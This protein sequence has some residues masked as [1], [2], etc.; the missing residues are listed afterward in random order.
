MTT[1]SGA[2]SIQI[3]LQRW[4][5]L[6]RFGRSLSLDWP[7]IVE[8]PKLD[9]E[10]EVVGAY[11]F[12][13][14]LVAFEVHDVNNPVLYRPP[15]RRPSQMPSCIGAAKCPLE[16]H[17]VT[18]H[19]QLFDIEAQIGERKVVSAD[20]LDSGGWACPERID[21]VVAIKIGGRFVVST[22]SDLLDEA[23]HLRL[24]FGHVH[25]S[26]QSALRLDISNDSRVMI[27]GHGSG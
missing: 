21:V 15:G 5:P 12:A 11:P 8:N 27:S 23:A 1:G 17:C 14:D 13:D 6:S 22:I 25:P 10:A 24:A 3:M 7:R 16:N 26:P 18:G 20:G 9:E 19:D 2:I 4:Q